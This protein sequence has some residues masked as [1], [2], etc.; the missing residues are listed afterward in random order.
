[1][2][3]KI[4][5]LL[6]SSIVVAIFCLTS[7]SNA[8]KSDVVSA[9]NNS[10]HGWRG[11]ERNGTYS[12]TGLLKV[13]AEDGPTLLWETFDV[14]KGYSSPVIVDD[15]IYVT[16]MTEDETK[17]IFSAYTLDGKQLYQVEYGAPWNDSFQDTRTTPTIV[18]D[19][20]YVI[21]GAGEI[22]CLSTA[23]GKIIWK[24]DGAEKFGRRTG[25]WGTSESP[26][27]FDNKVIFTPGGEQTS[28]VALNAKTGETVWQ[29][30]S[31]GEISTYIS[32]L[33]ITHNGKKQIVGAVW[34]NIMGVNPENGNIEWTFTDWAVEKQKEPDGKIMCNTPL[35][36]DGRIY[37]SNGY[38]QGSFM[39]E[40]NDDATAVK[41]LW[42]NDDLDTH[43]GGFVLVDGTLYGSNWLNNNSG[44]WVAV[45]WKTGETKYE[46]EWTG[47]SKGSIITADN[48]LYCYEER[49]GVVGLVTATPE[50]FDLVSEF[51]IVKGEGPHWAH[52]VIHNGILY[53]RHGSALMAYQIK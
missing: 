16:G 7:C 51:R 25:I 28:I 21:S 34:G 2:K 17:E 6:K 43:H 14:G 20:A 53:M 44:N 33:L 52:P 1:M 22:A 27:V 18:G 47:K 36:K 24:V 3:N 9:E 39:L 45:D 13:W 4:S 50:K 31:L 30:K 42:R 8:P 23:D 37:V 38:D 19:K 11:P 40:L 48:M 35:F 15:R 12:E 41:L 26:L 5:L 29:S 10:Q 32:P 46:H 49:R